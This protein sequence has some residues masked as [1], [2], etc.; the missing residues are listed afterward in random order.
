M[1]A[2]GERTNRHRLQTGATSFGNHRLRTGAH[3]DRRLGVAFTLI[4]LL[5][6]VT[7]LAVLV[8]ILLPGLQAAK[9]RAR[10]AVC[11]SNIRQLAAANLGY[12]TEYNGRL[13]PGAPGMRSANL[14]RWHG[15]RT[16]AS[17]PFDGG[18]SGRWAPH[19]G[20]ESGV[21]VCPEFR[22]R[23]RS[24]RGNAFEEGTGGY[25]YNQAYLGRVHAH[26]RGRVRSAC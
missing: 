23:R 11:G 20:G 3:T 4:E 26:G 18:R 7:I 12:A 9:A 13:C 25:G 8:S 1:E 21:R 2:G 14:V 16:S 5:V 19:L 6:V 15:V 10:A 24:S 17:E 22:A